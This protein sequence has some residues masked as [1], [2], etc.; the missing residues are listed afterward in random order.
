MKLIV[1]GLTLV[2][3]FAIS[4]GIEGFFDFHLGSLPWFS[5]FILAGILYLISK[6]FL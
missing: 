6:R 5:W 1:V 2:I 4:K 3:A